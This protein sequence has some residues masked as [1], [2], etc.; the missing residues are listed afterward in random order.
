MLPPG[1]ATLLIA[2]ILS[3]QDTLI[4]LTARISEIAQ[5][6]PGR[7]LIGFPFSLRCLLLVYNSEDVIY[8]KVVNKRD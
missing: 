1:C 6:S 5:E 3:H 2:L 7:N 8:N 4:N